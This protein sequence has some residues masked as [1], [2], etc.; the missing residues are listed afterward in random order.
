MKPDSEVAGEIIRRL[1]AQSCGGA[2]TVVAS[3]VN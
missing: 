3:T 1:L 2:A